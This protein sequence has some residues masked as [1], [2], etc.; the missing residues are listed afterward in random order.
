MPLTSW[1]K[2]LQTPNLQ[3][4]IFLVKAYLQWKEEAEKMEL[5][6]VRFEV[7]DALLIEEIGNFDVINSFRYYS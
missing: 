1:V 2:H 4:V 7:K 6:N 3:G 5:T